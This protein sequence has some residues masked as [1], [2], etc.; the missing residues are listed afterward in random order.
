MANNG[1]RNLLGGIWGHR[2]AAAPNAE[3][4]RFSPRKRE[5]EM[6]TKLKLIEINVLN[7]PQCR[8]SAEKAKELNIT[9]VIRYAMHQLR[10]PFVS[11]Q[12]ILPL[13]ED[14]SCIIAAL[15]DAIKNGCEMTAEWACAALVCAIKNLCI[16][17]PDL[18]RDY[19]KDLLACRVAYSANLRLL[20]ELCREHDRIA[21][22]LDEQTRRCQQ[23]RDH[24]KAC[25][26][27][28]RARRDSGELDG[29]LAELQMHAHAPHMLSDAALALRDELTKLHQLGEHIEDL[30]RFIDAIQARLDICKARIDSRLNTLANPPH[31]HDPPLHDRMNE[32][33]RRFREQLRRT[34]GEAE[35]SMKDY[36]IPTGVM[37]RL[38]ERS[39]CIITSPAPMQT[40]QELELKALHAQFL[41]RELRTHIEKMESMNL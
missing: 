28:Y 12:D 38:A 35:Q 17:M 20:P 40:D 13:D 19:A 3:E 25:M 1:I 22:E 23:M 5:N 7:N 6:L 2:P 14:L 9:G 39:V 30:E 32:T 15:N 10:Y 29:P 37:Q 18:D 36:A 21:R 4:I 34:L 33:N 16:D 26:A 8:L 27:S 31:V 11:E 24:K 41:Y